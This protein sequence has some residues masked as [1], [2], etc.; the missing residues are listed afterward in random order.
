MNPA[1]RL[2]IIALLLAPSSAL[3]ADI[4]FKVDRVIHQ[5]GLSSAVTTVTNNTGKTVDF[6]LVNCAFHGQ[7][8]SVLDIG[9]FI[10]KDFPAG[11]TRNEK[12]SIP[13]KAYVKNVTCEPA[14][15]YYR[16]ALRWTISHNASP[17]DFD[18]LPSSGVFA[19]FHPSI[20]AKYCHMDITRTS[21]GE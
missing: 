7:D 8:M 6:M 16:L 5:L 15:V 19:F 14:S 12:A 1:K 17:S 9:N 21:C 10:I 18:R 3:S 11:E 2:A 4:D 20:A 13:N